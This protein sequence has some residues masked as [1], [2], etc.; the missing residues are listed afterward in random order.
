MCV[1]FFYRN[2]K[3]G[4]GNSLQNDNFPSAWE[5]SKT[6]GSL[7][8]QLICW[9]SVSQSDRAIWPMW[10]NLVLPSIKVTTSIWR[11]L[12]LFAMFLL[13]LLLLSFLSHLVYYRLCKSVVL[14]TP[15]TWPETRNYNLPTHPDKTQVIGRSCRRDRKPGSSTFV[16]HEIIIFLC[17]NQDSKVQTRI[18]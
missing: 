14:K 17:R 15:T 16:L 8:S 7:T 18:Q 4:P 12:W 6:L 3:E 2:N 9:V 10:S 1:I 11:S 5:S 13:C